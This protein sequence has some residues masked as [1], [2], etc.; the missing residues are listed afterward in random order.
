MIFIVQPDYL[1]IDPSR[2]AHLQGLPKAIYTFAPLG[3]QFLARTLV[4]VRACVR[5]CASML[6]VCVCVCACCVCG[7]VCRWVGVEGERGVGFPVTPQVHDC[8]S[9]LLIS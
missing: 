7:C 6:C 3:L 8:S 2:T 9:N 1:A 5:A 4:C